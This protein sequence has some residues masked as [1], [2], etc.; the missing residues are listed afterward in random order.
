MGIMLCGNTR[1]GDTAVALD[2]GLSAKPPELL[3]QRFGNGFVRTWR[4]AAKQAR[5]SWR[6]Q[7]KR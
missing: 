3:L 7:L 2:Q 4:T 5:C 6:R 1:S